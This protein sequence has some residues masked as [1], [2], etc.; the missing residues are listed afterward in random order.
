[1]RIWTG[2][3]QGTSGANVS[4]E[5]GYASV[6]TLQ[7]LPPQN[8][9]GTQTTKPQHDLS[10]YLWVYIAI[11]VGSAI[12][13]TM[14][15][16]WAFVLTIRASRALFNKILHTV[17]R[18]PLRWLD[19]VPV[20]RVLNRFTSDFGII[21]SRITVD[22]SMLFADVLGLISVCIAAVFASP[23]VV[24]L[25]ALLIAV[26]LQVAKKYLD[27]A[28]PLKRLESNAKSPVFEIFNAALAGMPTIRGFQK[29]QVYIDRMHSNLDSWNVIALYMWLVNRWMGFRM[30]LIGTVFSTVVGV[31]IIY[32]PS[33]DAALAGF[34]LSFAIEFATNIIWTIRNYASM[35]LNMNSTERVVEYTELKTESQGGE[36]PPAAWPSSGNMEV[37]DLV[38][39]YAEDLPPVLK[40]ITFSVM[41][42]ERIGVVGRTGAGKSSLTLALFRFL[43]TRSGSV[44]IDGLDISKIDLHSL[45][46]RL[47]IIPQVGIRKRTPRNFY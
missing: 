4:Q 24:P 34:T 36:K 25:A 40:G 18:T 33:M 20:G 8:T 30:S 7:Q 14:R 23:Y 12:I 10:F 37:N 1:M 9:I 3:S 42:N 28:R 38:V 29:T 47:A 35:E 31:I 17:L 11:S 27:G 41:N 2:Q 19:T 16:Y 6:F 13:G 45:R 21:D 39:G 26:A 46:S 44:Y 32:S 5:H 15:F 43:E 22:W